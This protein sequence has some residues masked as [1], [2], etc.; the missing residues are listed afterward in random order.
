M[1]T[2]YTA[3]I[4]DDET[5]TFEQFIWRCARAFGA[6]VHMRDS[7][8]D[9]PIQFDRAR[10]FNDEHYARD[11]ARHRARLAE[12]AEMTEEQAA[13][14]LASERASAEMYN[15]GSAARDSLQRARY[16]KMLAA[17]EAWTPPTPDH[18]GLK[19]FMVQQIKDSMPPPPEKA[20]RRAVPT[21]T[22][23]EW[24]DDEIA[25]E[26]K[27]MQYAEERVAKAKRQ[28]ESTATWLAE[29]MRSVGPPP[30]GVAR[31]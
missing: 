25:D 24:I 2:G 29:L 13:A 30:Q 27:S 22:P 4:E 11:I 1:P 31:E 10:A 12:L 6:L 7:P 16:G 19:E 21:Q 15:A 18:A 5:Y 23:R 8:L 9:A 26:T 17:V 3:P 14:L 28:A 20:W